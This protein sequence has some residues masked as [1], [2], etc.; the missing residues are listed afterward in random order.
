[1]IKPE[2]LI[3]TSPLS[4]EHIKND[5]NIKA[6]DCFCFV[7]ALVCNYCV[8]LLSVIVSDW[9]V[10][11]CSVGARPQDGRLCLTHVKCL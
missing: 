10:T 4:D 2:Y 9:A 1:M 5:L 3:K 8:C 6:V 11:Q 7:S